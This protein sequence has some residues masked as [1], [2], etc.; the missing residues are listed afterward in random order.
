MTSNAGELYDLKLDPE[1]LINRCNDPDYK[2]VQDQMH[3]LLMSRPGPILEK[4]NEPV[5]MA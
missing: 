4:F 1:Q 2:K 3:Q 5:G